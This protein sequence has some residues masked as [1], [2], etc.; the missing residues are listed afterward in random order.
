M[1]RLSL[2]MRRGLGK[3]GRLYFR[4]RTHCEHRVVFH[5]NLIRNESCIIFVM[6]SHKE[7]SP[8]LCSG[9]MMHLGSVGQY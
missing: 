7:G 8:P 1:G 4:L 6:D 5:K 3:S 9:G 2:G